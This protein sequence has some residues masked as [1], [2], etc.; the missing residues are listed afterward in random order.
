M[1]FEGGDGRFCWPI[2]LGDKICQLCRLSDV[3]L[4]LPASLVFICTCTRRI[5]RA[6]KQTTVVAFTVL[7]SPPQVDESSQ[8]SHQRD[9]MNRPTIR[10]PDRL[11][12]RTTDHCSS[13]SS[14]AQCACAV[15]YSS[16]RR[17]NATHKH[18]SAFMAGD[19]PDRPQCLLYTVIYI[20]PG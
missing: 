4:T 10:Q 6:I 16:H 9:C 14:N 2:L 7:S 20:Y 19:R 1:E 3:P 5:S 12:D 8:Y 15:L 13:S 18:Q 11:T 17:R